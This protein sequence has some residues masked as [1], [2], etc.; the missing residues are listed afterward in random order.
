[1]ME[2]RDEGALLS[3]RRHGETAAIIE[4]FTA[5]HGRHAGVVRG[6]TSRKIAPILQPGAQLDVTWRARL[7]EHIGAFTV[8]PLR[9]RAADLMSDRLSLAGLNAVTAL[10]TF[11]LP[12]RE[13]HPRLYAG[14][15]ALL[16]MIGTTEVWPLAYLRWEMA[17]LE[18]MGF[19]LDLSV[20]AATGAADDL[21]YVSPRT[22]RAVSRAGAGDWA[23]RLL[24]LS[25]A[26]TG[27]ATYVL[28]DVVTGLGTTG[29]FLADKLAPALG[30]RPLPEAR[31]RLLD[32][33]DRR[34]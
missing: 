11:A 21:I 8:E 16:D 22:G 23:D 24:P 15:I 33:L 6:G 13:A 25:P 27:T 4:V 14:T 17:L 2:W 34:S 5:T 1:M 28:A 9:S 12:E 7:D 32:A 19:A 18:E 20:C 30:H 26:M 31:Q 29:F 3:V 10:L